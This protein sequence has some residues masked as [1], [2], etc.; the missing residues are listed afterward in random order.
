MDSMSF[1]WTQTTTRGSR[2]RIAGDNG[3]D[4]LVE[5]RVRNFVVS[6]ND[7]GTSKCDDENKK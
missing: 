4:D 1:Q 2:G 5:E 7:H 3:R 6:N